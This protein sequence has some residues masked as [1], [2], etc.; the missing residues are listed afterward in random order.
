MGASAIKAFFGKSATVKAYRGKIHDWNGY[1]VFCTLHPSS[2]NY[3]PYNLNLLIDD[4][5]ILVRHLNGEVK[6]GSVSYFYSTG[7]M[8][9]N[10]HI[11]DLGREKLLSCDVETTGLDQF[12]PKFRLLSIA[13]S[14]EPT[15]GTSFLLEHRRATTSADD[16]FKE[17]DK[18]IFSESERILVGHNFKFDLLGLRTRGLTWRGRVRDTMIMSHLL[19]ENN[20]DKSLES[21]AIR[22]TDMGAYKETVRGNRDKGNM[23]AL[24]LD[25]LMHYNCQDT[26]A[27]I[28]LHNKYL[29][30]LKSQGMIPLM[31][32]QMETLQMLVDVEWEGWAIHLRNLAELRASYEIR[33]KEKKEWIWQ[34][35]GEINLNSS[36]QKAKFLYEDLGIDS[37]KKTDGGD[38]STAK[39][40]LKKL[41]WTLRGTRRKIV[42]AMIEYSTDVK[43]H[44]FFAQVLSNMKSD[45]K[46]HPQYRQTKMEWG[47]ENELGGTVTGRLSCK[48]PNVQQIPR[49]G[50]IK[51][52]FRSKWANGQLVQLDYSQMELRV[53]AEN[54]GDEK[55]QGI[56][57]DDRID[58][59]TAVG[60]WV[61]KKPAKEVTEKERKFTK[62]VNFGIAYMIGKYGLANKL[63]EVAGKIVHPDEAGRLIKDWFREFPGVERW[64]D[65]TRRE[66]IRYGE[67]TTLMGRKRHLA[68]TNP[69][70]AKGREGIRQGVN[71]L[72][73]SLASDITMYKAT[74]LWRALTERS[75]RA[76]IVAFVH[77]S[78]VVDAPESE[79]TRV[80]EMMRK[81]FEDNDFSDDFGFK[82]KVPLK[83]EVKSGPTWGELTKVEV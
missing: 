81:I 50:D 18:N 45:R 37:I 2:V 27:T 60:G 75:M 51:R 48:N 57:R 61:Y 30:E 64:I 69:S 59:H 70:T 35:S 15:R 65:S 11:R 28:R 12:D 31:D 26:D 19:D 46:V 47:E 5:N 22:D 7:N 63:S 78:V 20:P 43:R 49:E 52:I 16:L 74:I 14:S 21:L 55:M 56:F 1:S 6:R 41:L 53:L 54:S 82:M 62:Q 24:E 3:E 79:V 68:D 23:E 8:G 40:V 4:M 36:K 38:D 42:E 29:K 72:I 39:D 73:Q 25:A 77:D 17:L 33:I 58:I 13:F 83:I 44:S 66:L 34:Y 71:F 10:R 80:A 9:Y 32:F 67:V 76:K